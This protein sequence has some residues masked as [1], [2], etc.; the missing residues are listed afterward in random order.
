MFCL[1]VWDQ[2]LQTSQH[3][4]ITQAT[5]HQ[6]MGLLL[7]VVCMFPDRLDVFVLPEHLKYA[8]GVAKMTTGGQNPT[9]ND[10]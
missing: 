8:R 4:P 10:M 5:L 7:V 9:I 6:A 3:L 2:A 1:G